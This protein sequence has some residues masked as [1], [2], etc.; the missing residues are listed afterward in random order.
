MK[1]SVFGLGY[2]GCVSAASFAA[3]GHES[4]ASTSTPTRSRASTRGA[5]RSS[6]RARRL[7]RDVAAEDACGRR[8]HRGAVDATEVSLIC[9]GTPS[10]KQRQ[11]RSDLSR[12][13]L[14]TDR[15]GAEDKTDYHVVVVRSTVLPGRRTSV[16][17]PRSNASR[18]R[19]TVTGFGVTVNPE[20]LREGTA[21][22]DFR[23]PPLTLVGPTRAGRAAGRCALRSVDAPLVTTSIRVRRDGEVRE[24]H[25][26]RAEGR[27]SRTRSATSARGWTSTATR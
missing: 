27:A 16:V 11:P 5:A 9:V 20:F 22:K 21:L 26:A 8:R 18:A 13:R 17:I 6:S 10:R 7:I 1:V 25:L 4:S 2:V 19:N 12:T 24:Q 3:D 23:K 15:R 14:R